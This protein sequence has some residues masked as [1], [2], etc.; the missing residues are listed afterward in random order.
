MVIIDATNLILGRMASFAA[1]QAL[2]GKD[3]IIINCEKAM[4]TGNRSAT[5]ERYNI[6]LQRGSKDKGPFSYRKPHMFVKR[7]IRGMLP[8][9]R[10]NGKKAFKRIR[11][12]LGVPDELKNSKFEQIKKMD[13]SKLDIPKYTTVKEICNIMG[14]RL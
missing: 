14:W 9:K 13:I 1:R 5:L 6:R 11:C 3:V 12:Y 8:Y 7:A 2:L 10:E 4:V